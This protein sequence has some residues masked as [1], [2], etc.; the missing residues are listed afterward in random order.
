MADHTITT[1]AAEEALLQRAATAKWMTPRGFIRWCVFSSLKLARGV[2]I[3]GTIATTRDAAALAPLLTEN[4]GI[5][6]ELRQG[7]LPADDPD[8][9]PTLEVPQPP[10]PVLDPE[11]DPPA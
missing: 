2:E 11:P 1:T 7:I 4:D 8:R 10:P 5:A 3:A 9:L 6:A